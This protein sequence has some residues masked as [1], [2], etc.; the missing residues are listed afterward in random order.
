MSDAKRGRGKGHPAAP[1]K[2]PGK[3]E[4]PRDPGTRPSLEPGKT[5]GKAEGERGVS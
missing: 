2:T 5:P 1:G 4:G 3:A